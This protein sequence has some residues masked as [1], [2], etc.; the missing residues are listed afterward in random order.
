VDLAVGDLRGGL[1]EQ[2][3]F[4]RD[5]GGL[6][7]SDP[8]FAESA[9]LFKLDPSTVHLVTLGHDQIFVDSSDFSDA[10][11][12]TTYFDLINEIRPGLTVKNQTF[13]DLL[14]HTKYSTYGFGAD[15]RPWAI[16]NKTSLDFTIRPSASLVLQ[17]TAGIA[18][19][20]S[21]VRAGE[22]RGRGY[23][24]I[25][26]RDISVGALPDDRFQGPFNSNGQV[27]FNYFQDGS[28]GDTGLFL[29]S[30]LDYKKKLN[31][32]AGIR[33]DHYKADFTGRFN[34]EPMARS[35]SSDTASTFNA[36]ATYNLFEMLHP[37]FTYATSTYLELGQGSE[38]DQAMVAAGTYLQDSELY[39]GGLKFSGLDSRLF[40]SAAVFRQKRTA[41][42]KD[43]GDID[44]FRTT[45]LEVETRA[46][47]HPRLSFTGAY[48]WQ[49]PEQLN[50]PFLLGIPPALLGLSPQDGY[51]GRFIGLASIF[52]VKAPVTVPGQPA[53][54]AS[55]FGTYAF[56]RDAGVT[57]GTTAVAAVNTGYV[58][59]VRL[60]GYM[61]WRG[62]VF[63]QKSNW[64]MNL[65]ANNL[66]NAEYYQ[67][68]FLFWDVFIKPS[69]GRTLSLTLNYGF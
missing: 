45:G 15:Y 14:D 64:G 38:L 44:Y 6:F 13:Y 53:H 58:S 63:L 54:V 59:S 56:R 19:R 31:I 17:N 50:V 68:Q 66:F 69:E 33:V 20:Y 67:S 7:A 43:S 32:L 49:K 26:R 11:T 55:V 5:M 27:T 23:Q 35:T 8:G 36:S 48:T 21:G 65:A 9:R 47:V 30:N 51:A 4:T 3:A 10:F 29:L 37:Y 18:Y 2:F 25:D 57:L 16:E 60:P 40:A 34:G 1:L 62:S 42:N 12:L 22:S 24:V 46:A 61:V 39:E 52:D 28:Y 41:V